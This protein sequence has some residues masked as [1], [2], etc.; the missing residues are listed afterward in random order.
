MGHAI[1][2][3]MKGFPHARTESELLSVITRVVCH[4]GRSCLAKEHGNAVLL[5]G[6]RKYPKLHQI[7]SLKQFSLFMGVQ[8]G[9][10]KTRNVRLLQNQQKLGHK[11]GS[12]VKK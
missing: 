9:R 1:T 10:S 3:H 7:Y 5:H 12:R 2:N 11:M 6:S 8:F 4:Y